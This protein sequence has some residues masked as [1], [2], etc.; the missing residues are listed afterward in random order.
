MELDV[1]LNRNFSVIS[2]EYRKFATSKSECRRCSI[3]SHYKQVAQSEGQTNSPTFVFIGESYGKE[4]V[5]HVR[6]FIGRAGQLLRSELRKYPHVF[7][8]QNCLLTNVLSC[9]PLGNKFPVNSGGPWTIY[10]ED[11]TPEETLSPVDVVSHCAEQWLL[12]EI[13]LLSPKI[14]VT[15]GAQALM[16]IRNQSRIS[17]HHGSWEFCSTHRAW[18]F[19]IYHPSYIL[20]CQNDPAKQ[21]VVDE[22][23]RD[24]HKLAT[25]W[26]RMTSDKRFDM[27]KESWT[28][29]KNLEKTNLLRFTSVQVPEDD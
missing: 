15:V 23:R 2:E 7:T 1:V 28:L 25:S 18:T 17:D 26:H 4:E 24:M 14:I 11:G 5:E 8:K 16:Y 6:P 9:R 12:Q 27:D 3:Y 29:L 13:K 21:Y 22:F 20:R 19:P 10:D